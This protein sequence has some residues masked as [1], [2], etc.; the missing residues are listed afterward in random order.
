MVWQPLPAR[1][2]A[3]ALFP[4]QPL[5]YE[6]LA[7][8]AERAQEQEALQSTAQL[9]ARRKDQQTSVS[10]VDVRTEGT[11]TLGASATLTR[12]PFATLQLGD[13][14]HLIE[15][16][17]PWFRAYVFHATGHQDRV[18][19]GAPKEGKPFTVDP[20]LTE[21]YQLGLIPASHVFVCPDGGVEDVDVLNH[22][23]LSSMLKRFDET[24]S[25]EVTPFACCPLAVCI[26][27]V[28]CRMSFRRPRMR[29]GCKSGF[30]PERRVKQ[31]PLA[32]NQ[33]TWRHL[34]NVPLACLRTS[35]G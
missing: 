33:N 2:F 16:N 30:K 6:H 24:E 28:C 7:E 9:A 8:T 34:T 20:S 1:T 3:I 13:H 35:S 29:N 22:H 27:H 31:S 25:I 11:G 5:Q 23:L 19:A 18:T 15:A 32:R 26:D 4:F 10:T 21:G 12:S 14:C 17:G